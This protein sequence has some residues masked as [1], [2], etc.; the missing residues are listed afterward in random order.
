M[1]ETIFLMLLKF[2]LFYI[3]LIIDKSKERIREICMY[4]IYKILILDY[5][6]KKKE[7]SLKELKPREERERA[8]KIDSILKFPRKRTQKTPIDVIYNLNMNIHFSPRFLWPGSLWTET[9]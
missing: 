1:K 2:P 9:L 6:E 4:K 8:R 3:D 7:L 5:L